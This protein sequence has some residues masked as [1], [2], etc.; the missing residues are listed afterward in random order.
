MR[1]TRRGEYALR[2]AVDLAAATPGALVRSQ[3]VA[4]RQGIPP[5]FLPQIINT[6]AR[7]GIVETVRG[8]AGGIRLK[9]P[10][11]E[12]AVCRVIEAVEGEW[13][14]NECLVAQEPCR[15]KEGCSLAPVWARAQQALTDVLCSTTLDQ[16]AADGREPDV[17]SAV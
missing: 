4:E 15:R 9:E 10:P 2:A 8:A 17:S 13:A 1:L 7:A 3:D 5:K 16:L 6:L 12:I 14:L 11:R